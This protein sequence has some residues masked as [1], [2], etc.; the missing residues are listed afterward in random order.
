[1]ASPRDFGLERYLDLLD[2]R[3][4][5]DLVEAIESTGRTP[6]S[7]T[8]FEALWTQFLS[9]ANREIRTNL[10]TTA[11]G[12]LDTPAELDPNILGKYAAVELGG[13]TVISLVEGVFGDEFHLEVEHNGFTVT[14][15]DGVTDTSVA[16]IGHNLDAETDFTLY[17]FLMTSNVNGSHPEWTL[18]AAK[19]FVR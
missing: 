9:I 3:F 6:V 2:D 8:D 18:I 15:G 5:S 16:N 19:D 4:S 17:T 10:T 1:M 12:T 13:N 11:S 7:Q 14:F